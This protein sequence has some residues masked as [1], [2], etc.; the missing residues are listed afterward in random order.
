M[1]SVRRT[2][3]VVITTHNRCGDLTETLQQLRWLDPC[4]DAILVCLDQCTDD[5]R[6][7]LERDFPECTLLENKIKLGSVPSRD[8]AFRLAKTDLILSLD[9]DSYPVQ[10]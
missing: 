6:S 9:D 8:R 10:K 4:P 7:M 1:S 5:S 2:C 3:T